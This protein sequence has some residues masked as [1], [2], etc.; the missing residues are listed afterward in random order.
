VNTAYKHLDS[1]LR[2]AELTLWQWVGVIGGLALGIAWGLYISPLGSTLTMV[3]S[4]YMA[5]LPAAAAL[6][7]RLTEFDPWLV[8]RSA[9]AWRRLEG[10]FVAGPGQSA[11]GYVVTEEAQVNET[12]RESTELDLASLWEEG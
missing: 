9:L 8:I 2:I 4:V 3:S 6:F 11:N 12:G 1:K 5:A 10:Q 7:A